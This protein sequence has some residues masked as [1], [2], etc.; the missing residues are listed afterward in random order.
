MLVDTKAEVDCWLTTTV[1]IW[2]GIGSCLPS[3]KVLLK[4]L[5]ETLQFQVVCRDLATHDEIKFQW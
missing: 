1:S 4:D 5:Q 3:D 2:N